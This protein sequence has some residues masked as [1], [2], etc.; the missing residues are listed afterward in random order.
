MWT[1]CSCVHLDGRAFFVDGRLFVHLDAVLPT[2]LCSRALF[3][4]SREVIPNAPLMNLKAHAGYFHIIPKYF[5]IRSVNSTRA[6]GPVR[7]VVVMTRMQKDVIIHFRGMTI[8]GFSTAFDVKYKRL[9][10]LKD[11]GKNGFNPVS[12]PLL[13]V[14]LALCHVRGIC[15]VAMMHLA[16]CRKMRH[17]FILSCFG[18]GQE[19]CHPL[20]ETGKPEMSA[21]FCFSRRLATSVTVMSHSK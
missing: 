3:I 7:S 13:K 12:Q 9:I 11:L 8:Y 6:C 2:P 5:C 18:G 1:S 14:N 15:P 20:Q 19:I 21:Y 17:N 10:D 16:I 4:A